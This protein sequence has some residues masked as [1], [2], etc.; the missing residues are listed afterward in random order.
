M[1]IHVSRDDRDALVN[2]VLVYGDLLQSQIQSLFHVVI[3]LQPLSCHH[4]QG[5]HGVR[6][7]LRIQPRSISIHGDAY[8]DHKTV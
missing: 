4:V 7:V 6:E 8:H 5:V 2:D 1:S 3:Q